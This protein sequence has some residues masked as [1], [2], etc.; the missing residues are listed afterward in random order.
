MATE[1]STIK[2]ET[3]YLFIL[4]A[5]LAGFIAG[6]IFAVYKLGPA[7]TGGNAP[8]AQVNNDQNQ[9]II[10]LEG[11]VTR[12]PNNGEAWTRLGNLYYDSD[13]AKKAIGAYTR[14]LELIQPNANVIT[15]LGVMYR[16]DQQP[17]KAVEMFA[18][19]GI[20]DPRHEQSRLNQAIVLHYDL[21][22]HDKAL[23]VLADLLAINPMAAAGNGQPVSSF[24]DTIK[25]AISKE[26]APQ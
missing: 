11:E 24:V 26:G 12:N 20:I 10:N 9:A 18:R 13:Q 14:A 19:A 15:D 6:A 23:P 22:E 21:H 3:L 5:F 2:K 17:Q 7:T 16:S 25:E 1:Q 4:V 8:Q